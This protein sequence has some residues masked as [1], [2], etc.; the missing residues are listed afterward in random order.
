MDAVHD[1]DVSPGGDVMGMSGGDL[2]RLASVLVG[3]CARVRRGDLVTIVADVGA[4]GGAEAVFAE[5]LRAGGHPEVWPR[6]EG[7]QEL[8]LEHEQLQ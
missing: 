8:V 4:W 7:L 3:H 6:S 2:E 5:V 1:G